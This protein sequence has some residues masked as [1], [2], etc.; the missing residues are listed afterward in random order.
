[1]P[2]CLQVIDD[3]KKMKDLEAKKAK[4]KKPPSTLDVPYPEGIKKRSRTHTYEINRN[5]L[6]EDKSLLQDGEYFLH[7]ILHLSYFQILIVVFL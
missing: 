7:E 1:M 6:D 3:E 5:E 4:K 2:P